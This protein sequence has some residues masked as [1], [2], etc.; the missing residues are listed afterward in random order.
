MNKLTT[1]LLSLP[2]VK[3]CKNLKDA[4]DSGLPWLKSQI[5]FLSGEFEMIQLHRK[6][7]KRDFYWLVNNTDHKKHCEVFVQDAGGLA[8]K[9]D[10][11]TGQRF[12]M[13]SEEIVGGSRVKLEFKPYEAY[14]LVF[15][16][17]QKAIASSEN[18]SGQSRVVAV[19]DGQWKVRIDVNAQPVQAPGTKL[20]VPLEFVAGAGTEKELE[21]WLGWGLDLFSGYVDYTRSFDLDEIDGRYI[22]D[23]GR[24][25][26]IAEVWINGKPAGSKLWPPFEFDVTEKLHLGR[27]EIKVRIGN[28]L[29]NAVKQRL[30]AGTLEKEPHEYEAGML[31]PVTINNKSV[32]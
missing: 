32:E 31:G 7:D 13:Q 10:C 27:N 14:W 9:W 25:S 20:I 29:C 5:Q 19:L 12:Q 24:V 11:E 18:T 22:L 23:L 26:Y 3:I 4:I 30:T 15:D 6:I 21:G 1:H 8:A 28:L 16:P 2:S 17:A